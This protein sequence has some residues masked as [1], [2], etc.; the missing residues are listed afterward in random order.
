MD[1]GGNLGGERVVPILV[2]FLEASTLV[3]LIASIATVGVMKWD[4]FREPF[5]YH[6][7]SFIGFFLAVLG[8]VHM[9]FERGYGQFLHKW[10]ID[11]I[12]CQFWVILC[13]LPTTYLVG[14]PG[15]SYWKDSLDVDDSPRFSYLSTGAESGGDPGGWFYGFLGWPGGGEF[16]PM[17][18]DRNP[19]DEDCIF[20]YMNFVD[21]YGKFKCR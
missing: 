4:W 13:Y 9:P 11:G 12:Y 2:Q 18:Q 17:T 5:P 19:W 21:F 16:I 20:T 6:A 3:I 10:Y 14:E 15:N 1:Y 7:G 8:W